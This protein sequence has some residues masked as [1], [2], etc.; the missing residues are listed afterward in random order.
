MLSATAFAAEKARIKAARAAGLLDAEEAAE[1]IAL[2][3][4]RVHVDG[5]AAGG[6]VAAPHRPAPPAAAAAASH[7]PAPPAAAAAAAAAGAGAGASATPHRPAAEARAK[8][9]QLFTACIERRAEDAL[10]LLDA[11]ADVDFCGEHG[12]TPL[13]AASAMGLEAVVARLIA[14]GAKL[15]HVDENGLSALMGASS[16]GHTAIAQLLADRGAS[17][18]HVDDK[19][20]SALMSA[21]SKGHTA[22]VQLLVARGANVDLVDR[23][24]MSALA[25][26]ASAS[27][28]SIVQRLV[29]RMGADSINRV[30]CE[31]KTALDW[32]TEET[33]DED[34]DEAAGPLPTAAA[35]RAHGGLTGAE[36]DPVKIGARKLLEACADGRPKLA[37]RLV[38]AGAELDVVDSDGWSALD[39]CE[40]GS[41]SHDMHERLAPVAE[42]IRARGGLTGEEVAEY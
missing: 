40:S 42:E 26:A 10:R 13:I 5:G 23:G 37:M 36:V 30:G 18:D 32:A 17:L 15:E 39:W 38:E 19:G 16:H 28:T 34:A 21:S 11:G 35:I 1:Q 8:G 7:R 20:S 2:L 24:G 3:L 22:I 9:K 41:R 25:W 12:R 27:H 29:S 14:A 6:K 31:G 33:E 4:R